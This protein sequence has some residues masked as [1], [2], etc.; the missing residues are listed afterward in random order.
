MTPP[1]TLVSSHVG[2]PVL[3]TTE[4]TKGVMARAVPGAIFNAERKAWLIDKPTPRGAA[5]ALKL[6]PDIAIAHPELIALRDELRHD[7]RPFDNAT[8]LGYCIA[9]QVPTVSRVLKE[10]NKDFYNFQDLDLGYLRRVIE[11]HGGAYLGWER[12]L[13]KT[14]GTCTLIE[15]LGCRRTLVVCPNTA[16]Q[17]VWAAELARFL[18][19]HEVDVMPNVKRHREY[20]LNLIRE[21]PHGQPD[22][23]GNYP[24]PQILVVHYEALQLIAKE[25]YN[26]RGWDTLGEW[27]LV[28]AD[29]AHRLKN[30]KALMSKAIKK[31]PSRRRLALSGSIVENHLEEL[32]SVLQW[33]FPDTYRSKWRDWNDRYLDYVDSGYGRVCVGVKPNRVEAMRSELGVFMTFR[34]KEDEL[35]LPPK[36]EQT[37]LVELSKGQRRVYD[38]LRDTCLARLDGGEVVTAD[39]GLVML[40]R[41]R[42]VATGL[43][44]LGDELRDSSKL[45]LALEM[46]Q[47]NPDEAFVVFSWF[48]AAARS[49]AER[50]T[51]KGIDNFMVTGDV[52]QKHRADMI[53]QFQEGYGQVFVG[54]LST[55]GESV[56]LQ[57]AS[58]AVFIDRSWNPGLNTQAADR[59]YRIGQDKPV[60]ITHL[61][62]RDTVDEVR[63]QPAIANK[64]A[65]RAMILGGA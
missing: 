44:T 39:E 25:R 21:Y 60:T 36:T 23:D 32:F 33:L 37:L 62:A 53:A 34:R 15:A 45:D 38:E 51:A 48:K 16:K 31:I 7:V 20:L 35:G 46:I 29:E 47:D 6:F 19:N 14:L 65:L 49:M 5:V 9:G 57:R 2:L 22:K 56:N 17:S 13:G 52:A 54:T 43:D 40:T 10:E 55:L 18:P 26:N 41:L 8:E 61:V 58:N 64:E 50:L 42:Q 63:V 59:I 11:E 27:D 30:P 1:D 4:Y 24:T 3:L 12:G 28:V